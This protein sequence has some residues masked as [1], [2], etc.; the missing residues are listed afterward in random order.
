MKNTIKIYVGILVV[1]FVVLAI[2]GYR[3]N[4][5]L[6]RKIW[7]LQKQYAQIVKDPQGVPDNAIKRVIENHKKIIAKYPG[8][9]PIITQVYFAL[10][11]LYMLRKDYAQARE[12]FTIILD[13]YKNNAEADSEALFAIG[14]CYELSGKWDQALGFYQRVNNEY[15]LTKAGMVAIGYIGGYYK[16]INDFQKAVDA[17]D[18]AIEF[19]KKIA[20]N[21]S[22]KMAGLAAL[23]L[24]SD[25]Y[26]AQDRWTEALDNYQRIL[27]D[28]GS[29]GALLPVQMQI[30]VQKINSIAVKELKD[31][32]A[33]IAVYQQFLDKYPDNP[34]SPGFKKL[35]QQLKSVKKTEPLVVK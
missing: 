11:N 3:G 13:V 15:P 8:N 18:R 32:G 25:C 26:L 21:Y 24:L 28:Y 29:K 17:F 20:K 23:N 30:L 19:Y 5:S 4:Y 31:Y 16:K 1:I 10:G 12:E 9:N 2:L 33:A 7:G 22:D 35:V 34:F 27:L 6:E 14:R